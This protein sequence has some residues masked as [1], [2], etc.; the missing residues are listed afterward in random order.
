MQRE[1]FVRRLRAVR[2]HGD[3]LHRRVAGDADDPVLAEVLL[4]LG[5]TLEELR[6]TEEQLSSDEAYVDV[7]QRDR[8]LYRELFEEAP[9]AYL[10]TDGDGLVRRANLRA[11]TLL[12]VDR[13]W[14]AGKPLVSFVQLS[15]RKSFRQRLLLPDG[16][17]GAE[18]E[19]RLL[20]R[21]GEVVLARAWAGRLLAQGSEASQQ[22]EAVAQLRRALDSRIAIEQAK[23]VLMGRLLTDEQAAFEWLRQIARSS[24]RRI[25]DVA[26]EVVAGKLHIG[27]AQPP[28]RTG[29]DRQET[30]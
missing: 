3:Q 4:E 5:T 16:L 11:S 25:T 20:P 13:Q 21:H 10:V 27:T 30:S 9:V 15:G 24:S 14:L 22:A 19:L 6:V 17:G 7:M 26:R 28:D 2:N 18:W 1:R 29:Q 8:D 23:G 12:G